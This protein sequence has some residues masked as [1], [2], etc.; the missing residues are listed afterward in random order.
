MTQLDLYKE[1]Y[2]LE[3]EYRPLM[4][5]LTYN[6]ENYKKTGYKGWVWLQSKLIYQPDILFIGYNPG[7]SKGGE[8]DF[9][10]PLTGERQFSCFEDNNAYYNHPREIATG[11]PTHWYE[12]NEPQNNSFY[13]QFLD[14]I[15]RCAEKLYS[16]GC[17]QK[18][19]KIPQ[20]F[21]TVE[22]KVSFINLYPIA[23]K[24]EKTLKKI[25]QRIRKKN[26]DVIIKLYKKELQPN[27]PDS[28]RLKD[29]QYPFIWKAKEF[30]KL[31]EPKL[32]VCLGCETFH[33]FTEDKKKTFV[34]KNGLLIPN[35]GNV[36]D[37][38]DPDNVIGMTRED[39]QNWP[40]EAVANEIVNRL[41]P[42]NP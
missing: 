21:K 14:I 18:K 35:R 37:L 38:Y 28:L 9:Y 11:Q 19:P 22:E 40:V 1:F 10:F 34:N 23:A 26:K 29:L 25:L 42:K 32:T 39:N 27:L 33:E 6:Q 41:R 2:S 12:R 24:D 17:N 31:I 5:E 20:W 8:K 7:Q 15:W 13:V 36:K 16:K 3:N 30:Q 4:D